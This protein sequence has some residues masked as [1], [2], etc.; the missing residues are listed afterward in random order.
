MRW[1]L[2]RTVPRQTT[3]QGATA[4]VRLALVASLA[5]HAVLAWMLFG[6]SAQPNDERPDVVEV[7]IA[8]DKGDG[9]HSASLPTGE[10]TA[11][12]GGGA[13][14]AN[15]PARTGRLLRGTAR[16]SRTRES[17]ALVA[18][19]ASGMAEQPSSVSS[20]G[21]QA[22]GAA[23]RLS[24]FRPAHPDLLGGARPFQVE[25]AR[26]LLAAPLAKAQA[27]TGELPKVLRGSGG[28]TARVGEDGSI[29]F[30]APKDVVMNDPSARAVGDGAG[31]GFGGSFDLNDQIMKMAGQDPYASAKRAIA[32]ETR[33]ERLCMARRYQGERKKQELFELAAKVRRLAARTD[34]AASA[35]RSL[36]FDIWDECTEETEAATDFGAMARATILAVVREVFPAGTD[37]A[38]QPAELLALNQRRSSRRHFAPYDAIAAAQ[39]GPGRH[40][41]AGVAGGR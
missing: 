5:V 33:E 2:L 14:A 41:D 40:P 20:S 24:T 21:T 29:H 17:A 3:R 11:A 12:V 18:N 9:D 10:G 27:G 32:D 37:R 31:V 8:V 34:L 23:D 1:Q 7:S 25:K 6:R 39:A 19:Q 36:I 15:D 30:G 26:D 16:R 4:P 13:A 22:V 35:R 28:V 38:Y